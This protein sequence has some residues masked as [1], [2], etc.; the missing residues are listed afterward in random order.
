MALNSGIPF[1]FTCWVKS[2]YLVIGRNRNRVF[3]Y[4]KQADRQTEVGS[5]KLR[6]IF[7]SGELKQTEMATLTIDIHV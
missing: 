4:G 5:E 2:L 1:L 6:L 3:F 7:G